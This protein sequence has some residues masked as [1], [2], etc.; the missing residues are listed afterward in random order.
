M[1]TKAVTIMN[2]PTLLLIL[3]INQYAT[4]IIE[5]IIFLAIYKKHKGV[6]K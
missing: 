1:I 3:I 6:I 4:N 5:T 2:I